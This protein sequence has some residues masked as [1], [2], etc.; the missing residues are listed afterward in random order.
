M[1]QDKKGF[2]RVYN[3]VD[4]IFKSKAGGCIFV[5][6]TILMRKWLVLIPKC[7]Q[8]ARELPGTWRY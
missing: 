6:K 4:I 3:P 7:V 5:G 2:N 8:E 1:N